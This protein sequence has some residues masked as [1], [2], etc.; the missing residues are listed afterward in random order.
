MGQPYTTL[1][2]V[3]QISD[4]TLITQLKVG[5][6]FFFNWSIVNAGGFSSVQLASSGQYGGDR[7]TLRPVNDPEFNNGQVWESFR[8]EWI[9]ESGYDYS[10]SP[11]HISGVYVGGTFH[12]VTGVG[13][14]KHHIDYP[15][16]RIVFE[17]PI[18]TN[19]RVQA[20]YSYRWTPFY[21]NSPPWFRELQFRSNHIEDTNF[22]GGSGIWNELAED[23]IQLPS[24]VI[25]TGR[26]GN[27]KGLML[28]GGNIQEQD[29]IFNILTD[30]ENDMDKLLDYIRY[31]WEKDIYLFDL[32]LLASQN[33]FPLDYR[34]SPINGAPSY[35]Q[36]VTTIE[37]GGY[38]WKYCRFLRIGFGDPVVISPQFQWVACRATMSIEMPQLT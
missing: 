12:P 5:L 8:K 33:K 4:S 31:Q 21:I 36:L 17:S 9:W 27:P 10:P 32:N 19:S 11:I 7:S 14:F 30:N 24:V 2:G 28:G 38:R 6:Q 25:Q 29:T 3:D 26:A 20:E 22:F 34:G 16:G 37:D 13:S 18:S 1:K 35:P 23:R 15:N